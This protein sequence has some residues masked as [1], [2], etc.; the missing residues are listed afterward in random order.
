M[1]TKYCVAFNVGGNQWHG[2]HESFADAVNTL[3]ATHKT[4]GYTTMI[5]QGE[6]VQADT[7]DIYPICDDCHDGATYHDYPI[8]RYQIGPRGGVVCVGI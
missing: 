4:F 8:R 7:A 6:V 5:C 3:R 1:N 2:R